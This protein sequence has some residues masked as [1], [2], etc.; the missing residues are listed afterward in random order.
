MD[1]VVSVVTDALSILG[2]IVSVYLAVGIALAFV[3]GQ[4]DAVAGRPSA[5]DISSRIVLLVVC[6]ALVALARGVSN[7]I[8]ALVGGELGDATAVRGAVLNVGQY[9]LD[10]LIASAAI[11]L[12]VG[13]VTGFVGA[14]LATTAGEPMMLSRILG[15]LVVLTALAVGAFLTIRLSHIVIGAFR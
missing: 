11:L 13:V 1:A 9:F 8:A 6:V 3:E 7:D 2:A 12:A 10:I 15:K 4:I 14:Q 5:R